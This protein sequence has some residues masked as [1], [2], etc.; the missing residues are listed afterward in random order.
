MPIDDRGISRR[1]I[2]PNRGPI[3]RS[4]FQLWHGPIGYSLRRY[5]PSLEFGAFVVG[6]GYHYGAEPHPYV[7]IIFGMLLP[8]YKKA[9]QDIELEALGEPYSFRHLSNTLKFLRPDIIFLAVY[10]WPGWLQWVGKALATPF[11]NILATSFIGILIA[12]SVFRWW[13]DQKD[14]KLFQYPDDKPLQSALFAPKM[15]LLEIHRWLPFAGVRS[16]LHTITLENAPSYEAISYTWGSDAKTHTMRVNGLPFRTTTATYNALYSCSLWWTSRFIW[17]DYVCIDQSNDK[18]K[19]SQVP[20][21]KNIYFQASQVIVWLSEPP[22]ES[23]WLRFIELV[24]RLQDP[25][26]AIEFIRELNTL[27][28]EA[29]MSAPEIAQII[30]REI[31]AH[32]VF[33]WHAFEDFLCNRW[34]ARVWIVQEVAVASRI[35]FLYENRA[36][37]WDILTEV[38]HF[39]Q[40]PEM[41]AILSVKARTN[42][43]LFHVMARLRSDIHT[44]T[45]LD[46]TARDNRLRYPY[47][48]QLPLGFLLSKCD[49]FEATD[50]RDKVY[51]LL[52][53]TTDGSARVLRPSYESK[54][55]KDV[56]TDAAR[57]LLKTSSPLNML[58]YAGIST[59]NTYGL[60]SW[61]PDWTIRRY[62]SDL[63]SPLH[64]HYEDIKYHASGTSSPQITLDTFSGPLILGG[65]CV[66]SINAVGGIC[67]FD[68]DPNDT[69][70][71]ADTLGTGF[72]PRQIAAVCAWHDEAYNLAQ[73]LSISRHRNTIQ[74]AFWRTLIG[75]QSQTFRPA[76]PKLGDDYRTWISHAEALNKFFRNNGQGE[77]PDVRNAEVIQSSAIWGTVMGYCASGR[78][79]AVTRRGYMGCV[80][81]T[82]KAGDL[83][84][85]ILGANTPY[86]LRKNATKPDTY[87]LV[88]ECYMDGMMDGE[89]MGVLPRV[90][91]LSIV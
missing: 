72:Y 87:L 55:T 63:D 62:H 7:L 20:L 42:A 74:E 16:T 35:Q 28:V 30:R 59:T 89:M 14:S 17:I 77:M 54:M 32:R 5:T 33:R 4:A 81:P 90:E 65:A 50:A 51:S 2:P 36:I 26:V 31:H 85:I 84:A 9:M 34:F 82:S 10:Y 64:N 52:G 38:L 91:P 25:K 37:D 40:E 80:P 18:E 6:M 67:N 58:S 79:F 56:F 43:S 70:T 76:S 49:R 1:Q 60:P 8:F 61:V 44:L 12:A 88:G 47:P 57:Y 53:L 15:R 27:I 45:S 73:Y 75:D 83:V 29:Q 22:K 71:Y 48:V 24:G 68:R 66:D 11:G 78:R 21:M 3:Y 46:E 41:A 19:S 86:V 23:L 69:I 13:R 39:F